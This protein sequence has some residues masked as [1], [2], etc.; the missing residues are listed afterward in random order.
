MGHD[1][2][3]PWHDVNTECDS[4]YEI[5]I[6]DKT[7]TLTDLNIILSFS[8]VGTPSIFKNNFRIMPGSSFIKT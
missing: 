8:D 3:I 5:K 6:H 1:V 4:H 7:N 2:A